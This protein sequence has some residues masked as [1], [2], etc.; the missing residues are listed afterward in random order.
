MSQEETNKP[1]RALF[2]ESSIEVE[3]A[4]GDKPTLKPSAS[5]IH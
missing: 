2:M 5:P 3:R 4:I 1:E